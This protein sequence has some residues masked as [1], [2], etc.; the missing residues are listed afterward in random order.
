MFT[1]RHPYLFFLLVLAA[2]FALTSIVLS[3]IL[4]VHLLKDPLAPVSSKAGEKVGVVEVKGAIYD[5]EIVISQ[6]KRFRKDDSIKAIVLRIESPGGSV[7]PTQEIFREVRKTSQN[8]TVIASMGGIAA[9]GGYYIASGANGIVANPGTITGSIGVILG[10]TN[11]QNLL[12]KVGLAPVIVKSGPYKDMGSSTRKMTEEEQEL[13]QNLVDKIHKQFIT[14]ISEG[15]NIDVSKVSSMADGRILL[16]QEAKE[17][18]LVDRLG[19][20][21]DALEWAGRKGG[22]KGEII[23]VYAKEKKFSL[24]KYIVDSSV[25]TLTRYFLNLNLFQAYF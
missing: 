17:L 6:L 18:G 8:K 11:F 12:E 23:A 16:G 19:N 20:F 2:I 5:P 25:N 10:Y 24:V 13:L 22:I 3:L 21:E 7:G 14:D 15:R 4:A 9:S 1:R